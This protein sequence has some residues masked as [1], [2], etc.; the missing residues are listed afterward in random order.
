MKLKLSQLDEEIANLENSLCNDSDEFDNESD[1]Q[2]EDDNRINNISRE[3]IDDVMAVEK[4]NQG[5]IIRIIS[6][7]STNDRIQPLPQH[8]L[9]VPMYSKKL[10]MNVKE[11]HSVTDSKKR[12]IS[13]EDE[14][15]TKKPNQSNQ[16]VKIF[17]NN[18]IPASRVGGTPFWC[19]VCQYQ[20]QNLDEF[21]KH[22]LSDSHKQILEIERKA[23][24]CKL[25][26]KQFTSPDQLKEHIHGNAHYERLQNMKEK[27]KKQQIFS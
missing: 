24:Y 16:N 9:P 8:L 4:D 11:T 13:F 12:R 26:R 22:R 23:S 6:N 18:Y 27:T 1:V 7:L 15:H 2:D 21:E 25:C 20:G 19:R 3:T 17:Q 5:N 14:I 10:N